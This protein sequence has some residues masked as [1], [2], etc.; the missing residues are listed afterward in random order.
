MAIPLENMVG[1]IRSRPK[2]GRPKELELY[3]DPKVVMKQTDAGPVVSKPDDCA[4]I[5]Y[6][7]GE[8]KLEVRYPEE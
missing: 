2:P 3:I 4:G 8:G 1:Y 7:A 6:G 5:L